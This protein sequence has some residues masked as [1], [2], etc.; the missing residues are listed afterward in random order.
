MGPENVPKQL[1]DLEMLRIWQIWD[2]IP[3]WWRL[4]RERM[5]KVIQVQFDHRIRM[6]EL[7]VEQLRQIKEI[8]AG[9]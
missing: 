6:K 1:V 9:Q 3:D 7:E 5:I 2:P 8:V 4:D